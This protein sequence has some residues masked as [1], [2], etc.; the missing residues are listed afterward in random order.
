MKFP[1]CLLPLLAL[2]LSFPTFAAEPPAVGGIAGNGGG[3][4]KEQGIYKTFYSAGFYVAAKDQTDL[5]IPALRSLMRQISGSKLFAMYKRLPDLAKALAPSDQR[6]YYRVLPSA[7][8]AEVRAQLYAEYAK[9][10]G[11]PTDRMV[12]YAVTDRKTSS[13]YLLPEFDELPPLGQ[14]AILFHEGLW[15]HWTNPTYESV[16][17]A[18][19][20]FQAHFEAPED[21]DR[22]HTLCQKAQLGPVCEYTLAVAR[23]LRNPEVNGL[24]TTI[25]VGGER[26][27]TI[28]LSSL[29]DL[30]NI[31]YDDRYVYCDDMVKNELCWMHVHAKFGQA[32]ALLTFRY[33][34]SRFLQ[35]INKNFEELFGTLTHPKRGTDR[36]REARVALVQREGYWLI[37]RRTVYETPS[38]VV[39][40]RGADLGTLLKF[41]YL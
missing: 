37:D 1:P 20:A 23:D 27:T 36:S 41:G 10:T 12:I 13:T 9:V 22:Q 26:R 24:F 7:F 11:Q 40:S 39:D 3:G 2:A 17:Q 30:E 5:E 32:F 4:I 18:E 34:D 25:T 21:L 8:D 14:Q 28:K 19:A 15:V 31:S 38:A 29:I 16:L 33:P 35:W 6:K